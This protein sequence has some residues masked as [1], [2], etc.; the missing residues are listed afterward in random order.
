MI[1]ITTKFITITEK[2]LRNYVTVTITKKLQKKIVTLL[3][4]I[5]KSNYISNVLPPNPGPYAGEN[6]HCR[7]E[8]YIQ[9]QY[10]VNV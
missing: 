1:K 8:T 6:S 9:R 4:I 3:S 10:N 2:I 7:K 5:K